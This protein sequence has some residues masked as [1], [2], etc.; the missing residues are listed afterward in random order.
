MTN[1]YL[2][3][4]PRA[5]LFK[6]K[7]PGGGYSWYIKYYLPNGTRVRRPCGP[8]RTQSLKRLRLK[9]DELLEGV[10]MKRTSERCPWSA[11]SPSGG[12]SP[13]RRA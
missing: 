11:S 8:T 1:L 4:D 3:Y 5:D 7:K 6:K 13:S 10:L 12:G 9:V 2:G